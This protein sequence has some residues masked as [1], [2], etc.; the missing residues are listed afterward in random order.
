[1]RG[2][3]CLLIIQLFCTG[4]RWKRDRKA[5]HYAFNRQLFDGF[6]KIFDNE[7]KTLLKNLHA[8]FE[9]S[10]KPQNLYLDFLTAALDM[11]YRTMHNRQD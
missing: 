8:K 5:L 6:I 11:V 9:K 7:S 1:M 10:S 2:K 3:P 4:E